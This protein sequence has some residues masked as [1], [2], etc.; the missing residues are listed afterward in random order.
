M[1]VTFRSVPC[2]ACAGFDA[3]VAKDSRRIR[4]FPQ[5]QSISVRQVEMKRVALLL[6][7][8]R[9]GTRRQLQTRLVE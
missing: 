2:P 1:V 8:L 6:T 3:N 4:E 9:G 7:I 5:P